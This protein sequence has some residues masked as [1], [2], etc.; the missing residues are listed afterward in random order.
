MVGSGPGPVAGRFGRKANVSSLLE[1]IVNAYHGDIGI[2]SDFL[3]VENPHPQ[4]GGVAIADQ[5]PDP[6]IPA[7]TVMDVLM[8][9]RLL[10]PPRR[11]ERTAEVLRGETVF[12][13]IGCASCHVPQV[14][15]GNSPISAVSYQTFHLYSDLLLH[16]MGPALADNRPDGGADGYEWKTPPLWGLRLVEQALGGHAFYL[17]DGRATEL[18]SAI[19]LH[20][21]EAQPARD[22]FDQLSDEDKTALLAMLRSL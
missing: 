19:L 1:Q 14:T 21:G 7:A 10:E 16:D 8:Y 11:G 13:S 20:G 17:H 9:L 18:E 6:E 3:P 15:T 12:E 2:T 22:R 5:V 4:A